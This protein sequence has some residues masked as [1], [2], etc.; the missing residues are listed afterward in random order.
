MARG[1]CT[2][3]CYLL[4]FLGGVGFSTLQY[5]A[6]LVLGQ[7]SEVIGLGVSLF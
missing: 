4:A 3:T 2:A 6:R 5:E 7:K 1:E